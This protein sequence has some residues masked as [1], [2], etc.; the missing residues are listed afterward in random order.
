MVVSNK[1]K[2][3]PDLVVCDKKFL[4][5]I[6]NQI[7]G[8]DLG[9]DHL[10]LLFEIKIDIIK[11]KNYRRRHWI[12]ESLDKK[13]FSKNLTFNEMNRSKINPDETYRL[14]K[15][16]FLDTARLYCRRNK[17]LTSQPGNPWWNDDCAA[18]VLNKRLSFKD[19]KKQ[20]LKRRIHTTKECVHM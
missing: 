1:K 5:F 2:G 14:I 10:P 4:K 7:V 9:S 13:I 16:S 17:R 8:L 20:I 3:S 12:L 11:L 18:A 19:F 6:K 15:S